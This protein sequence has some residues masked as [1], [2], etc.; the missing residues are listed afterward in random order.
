M[1]FDDQRR[2]VRFGIVFPRSDPSAKVPRWFKYRKTC[3][4]G[5]S[6]NLKK[7]WY[8]NRFMGFAIYCQLPFLNDESPEN[9][10]G[11][12][13]FSLYWGTTITTK[14]VPECA[15]MDQQTLAKIVHLQVS[16]V[17]AYGSHDCFIFLQLDLTKIHFNG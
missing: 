12:S 16:N 17:V 15:A 13:P 6:F 9:P 1:V 11:H 14:L 3:S 7:H 8:N 10:N 2:G 4:M 5:I